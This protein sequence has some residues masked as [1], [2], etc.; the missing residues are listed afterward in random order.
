[1]TSPTLTTADAARLL[2]AELIGPGDLVL[3]GVAPI[4]AAGAGTLTF[5]RSARFA[6][7]WP[8]SGASA[9]LVTRGI[10]VPGHDPSARALLVVENADAAAAALLSLV[11][12]P[13][14]VPQPGVHPSAVVDASARVDPSAVVGPMCVVGAGAS[15]GPRARLVSQVTLGSGAS[16]GEGTV[17]HPGARVLRGCRVGKR[18]IVW[19]NAVIGADGFGYF[20]DKS[21]GLPTKIPHAGGVRIGDDVEIGANTSIDRGKLEDTTVGDFTKIDNQVQIGHNCR[22]GRGVIICGSCAVAGSVTI[23]DGAVLAGAVGVADGLTIGPGARLGAR[24]GVITDVPAGETWWGIPAHPVR[25]ELRQIS[26]LRALPDAMRTLR[27]L[28]QRA[29]V[30]PPVIP[31]GAGLVQPTSGDGAPADAS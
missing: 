11:T 6:R 16:V 29:G 22:I 10:E 12:P 31:R 14:A 17:V 30:D 27:E 2:G 24:S 1:M 3:S 9:A 25:A 15:V 23:G 26:V 7:L 4:D 8:S 19:S 18:C 13:E 5:I 28:A 21:T 20:T